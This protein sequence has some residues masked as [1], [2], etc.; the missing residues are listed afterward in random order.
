MKPVR[1]FV[2]PALLTIL[3]LSA[4]IDFLMRPQLLTR[5]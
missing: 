4:P 5:L 2:S 3:G 1:T